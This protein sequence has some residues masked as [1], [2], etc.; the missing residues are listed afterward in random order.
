MEWKGIMTCRRWHN[1]IKVYFNENH[2]RI[3]PSPVQIFRNQMMMKWYWQA[4]PYPNPKPSEMIFLQMQTIH[5]KRMWYTQNYRSN[6]TY[7]DPFRTKMLKYMHMQA[8]L[9]GSHTAGERST[10]YPDC[11]CQSTTAFTLRTPGLWPWIE[12]NA[13]TSFCWPFK[14]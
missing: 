7:W 5:R 13:V 8:P 14:E 12:E 4:A 2:D 1:T 3:D 11:C 6:S 9:K 10:R